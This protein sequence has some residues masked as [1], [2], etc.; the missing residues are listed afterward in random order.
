LNPPL[1]IELGGEWSSFM[2]VWVAVA[3]WMICTNY[4]RVEGLLLFNPPSATG[5]GRG[6][7]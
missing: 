4:I 5:V 6:A 2:K 3:V 1:S 7:E